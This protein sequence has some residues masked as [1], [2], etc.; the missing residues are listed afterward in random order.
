MAFILI[1]LFINLQPA[2]S[3]QSN[4]PVIFTHGMAGFDD[5]LGFYYWGDDYGSFVG[6]PSSNSWLGKG[7]QSYAASL[8]P[9]H[10]SEKRGL[11]L[12]DAIESYMVSVGA[13]HVNI[14]AHSQ[15]GLDAR[16][17]AK[18]L[19]QR[20]GHPVIKVI[21]SISS[22]HRGT[23]IA[24]YILDKR[25]G[26]GTIVSALLK[27][28]GDIINGPGNSPEA[29]LKQLTYD[30]YDPD[31]G[32]ITGAKVFNEKYPISPDYASW[33]VSL[34]T[35]QEGL[36]LNPALYLI[37]EL[38]YDIDGD[39]YCVDD[40]NGDGAAGM[41]DGINGD[42][43]DD[44]MVGINSQQMGYRLF[45]DGDQIHTDTSLG[46]VDD[47][48]HPNAAQMESHADVIEQDHIDVIGVGPDT[49]DEMKFYGAV[50]EY[51]DHY[52]DQ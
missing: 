12:A 19:A 9:I 46:Y 11:E 40:C 52:E 25:P 18:L 47:I 39:G 14:V 17:A 37:R 41:G 8:T 22:P 2:F 36:A 35:A 34:I 1:F 5:I 28:Y 29:A 50:I 26:V 48:N 4:Y 38:W 7:Q 42:T 23:P 51:I 32:E 20:K 21:C 44:G 3:A 10:S 6:D 15:G 45:Y 27:M 43:D 13:E 16:K 31:D 24:K 49:F 30:D 33:Y